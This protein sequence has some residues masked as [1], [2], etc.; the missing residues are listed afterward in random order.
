MKCASKDYYI[1]VYHGISTQCEFPSL[2]AFIHGPISTTT[3]LSVAINF[4]NHKGMI[5]DMNIDTFSWKYRA[6]DHGELDY[7]VV[8]QLC[9]FD[10]Q[11]FSDFVSEHEIFS[12]GGARRFIFN[13]I[14][15]ITTGANYVR[16][17]EGLKQMTY[18]MTNG[19]PIERNKDQMAHTNFEKH[20]MFRLLSNEL[21]QSDPNHSLA[22]KWR[23]CPTR[24][25]YLVHKHCQSIKRV[26]FD[27]I[28]KSC[29]IHNA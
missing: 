13:T 27:D 23:K 17:I 9:C 8:P 21:Y 26:K 19:E 3:D 1:N 18:C 5:L 28:K 11:F 24:I 14:I 10:C 20:M 7:N 16:Y 12:I 6:R 4:C 29:A 22:Y 2:N 15:D 25:K